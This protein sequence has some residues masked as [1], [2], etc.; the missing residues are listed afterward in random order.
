MKNSQVKA[1]DNYKEQ[2]LFFLKRSRVKI[3]ISMFG[4]FLTAICLILILFTSKRIYG[5]E[6]LQPSTNFNLIGVLL[7]SS[8]FVTLIGAGISTW[9]AIDIAEEYKKLNI[10]PEK[11]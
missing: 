10:N 11:K 6:Q 3:I 1:L 2:Y 4:C 5:K 7:A 8:A 9:L